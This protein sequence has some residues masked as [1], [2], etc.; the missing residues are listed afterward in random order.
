MLA[1]GSRKALPSGPSCTEGLL[2]PH[3]AEEPQQEQPEPPAG[4]VW[5]SVAVDFS[6]PPTPFPFSFY[7]SCQGLVV[8]L[9]KPNHGGISSK[10]ADVAEPHTGAVS[11]PALPKTQ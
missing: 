8:L 11:R 3:K 1:G 9:I 10:E 2:L 6:V 5:A 4:S 7:L